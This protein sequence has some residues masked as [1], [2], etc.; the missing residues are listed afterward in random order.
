MTS[1]FSIQINAYLNRQKPDYEIVTVQ[2]LTSFTSS[3]HS[4]SINVYSADHF[5]NGVVWGLL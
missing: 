4:L 1:V 3:Y 2:P 5:P